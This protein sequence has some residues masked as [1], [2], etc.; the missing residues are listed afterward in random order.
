MEIIE[1]FGPCGIGKSSNFDSVKKDFSAIDVEQLLSYRF[2]KFL[3]EFLRHKYMAIQIRKKLSS[4]SFRTSMYHWFENNPSL[5]NLIGKVFIK[6]GEAYKKYR[7]FHHLIKRIEIRL[8]INDGY[9]NSKAVVCIDGGIIQSIYEMLMWNKEGL[10]IFNNFL[11]ILP[12]PDMLIFFTASY[13][14]LILRI[15]ERK[16][17]SNKLAA[18]HRGHD[19]HFKNEIKKSIWMANKAVECLSDYTKIIYYKTI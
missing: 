19:G 14:E 8:L 9:A 2:S 3:P 18:P 17:N 11:D 15:A 13:D 5:I 10:S 6:N 1:T 4:S 12:L 7:G 16:N